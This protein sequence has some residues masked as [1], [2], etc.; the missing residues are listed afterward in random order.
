MINIPLQAIPGQ[1]LSIQLDGNNYD[2]RLH[3]CNNTPQTPG[4]AIMTVSIARNGI[5]IVD[6]V[7]PVA[8]FPIIGYPYLENG[9]FVIISN[10]DDYPDYTQFGITQFL[11]FASQAELEAIANGSFQY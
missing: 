7:R 5:S 8:G 4:T 2:I 9:N 6:N 1:S 10:N 11:I 3:S